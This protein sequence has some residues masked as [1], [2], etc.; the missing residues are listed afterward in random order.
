MIDQRMHTH[1]HTHEFDSPSSRSTAISEIR[2]D[3]FLKE[4]FICLQNV[5]QRERT[6]KEIALRNEKY[7]NLISDFFFCTLA[8]FFSIGSVI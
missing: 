6:A 1:S 7:E 4:L 3:Y 8:Q 5:R 2:L